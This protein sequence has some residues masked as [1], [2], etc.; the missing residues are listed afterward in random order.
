VPLATPSVPLA[1][2]SVP[3]ATPSVPLA[4]PSVLPATRPRVVA[5]A[6]QRRHPHGNG[7]IG[8]RCGGDVIRPPSVPLASPCARRWWCWPLVQ[9]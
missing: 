9:R 3:L 7:D 6:Q 8:R 1:T 5:T 2:P 4:R